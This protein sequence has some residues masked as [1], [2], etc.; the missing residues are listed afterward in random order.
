MF[1]FRSSSQNLQEALIWW[2]HNFEDMTPRNVLLQ[3]AVNNHPKVTMEWST[4]SKVYGLM[5][6]EDGKEYKK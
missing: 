3:R 5:K 2:Y 6:V 4:D 1:A